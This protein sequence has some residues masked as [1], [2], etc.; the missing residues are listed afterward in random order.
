MSGVGL[1]PSGA[2]AAKNVRDLQAGRRQRRAVYAGG[3][4]CEL[5]EPVV[6][7]LVTSR[8]VLMATRV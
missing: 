2:M 3:I 5:S 7:G 4:G 8:I 1:A 6:S